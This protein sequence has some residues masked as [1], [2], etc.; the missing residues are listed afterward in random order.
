[1]TK[2]NDD[3]WTEEGLVKAMKLTAMLR[4]RL[5]EAEDDSKEKKLLLKTIDDL[6]QKIEE[7]DNQV[8]SDSDEN[9]KFELFNEVF[10]EFKKM[11]DL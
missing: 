4:K 8:D 5:A 3:D 2:V 10:E 9:K 11:D 6:D 7:F 1:M